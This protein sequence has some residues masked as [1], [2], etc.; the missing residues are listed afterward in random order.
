MRVPGCIPV[1]DEGFRNANVTYSS[2]A[3]GAYLTGISRARNVY[4][5]ANA[6]PAADKTRFGVTAVNLTELDKAIQ[7]CADANPQVRSNII[8][9][10]NSENNLKDGIKQNELF[11]TRLKPLGQYKLIMGN[12]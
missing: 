10:Q 11:H 3:Y 12:K 7:S 6:L 4:D 5:M 1:F 2:V 8:L 9:R